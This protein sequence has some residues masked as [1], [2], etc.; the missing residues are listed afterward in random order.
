[1]FSS[2]LWWDKAERSVDDYIVSQIALTTRR[3]HNAAGV[4]MWVQQPES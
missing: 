3:L 2:N 4:S 1:M